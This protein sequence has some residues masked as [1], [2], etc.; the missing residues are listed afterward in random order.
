MAKNAQKQFL[1]KV[2]ILLLIL[3]KDVMADAKLAVQ[4]VIHVL[5]NVQH[6]VLKVV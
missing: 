5:L 1:I 6:P 2:K 4:N 3:V